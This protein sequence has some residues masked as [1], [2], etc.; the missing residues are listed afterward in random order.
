MSGLLAKFSSCSPYILA[1]ILLIVFIITFFWLYAKKRN[2]FWTIVI[3][4]VVVTLFLFAFAKVLSPKFKKIISGKK[5]QSAS[6]VYDT[7]P[8]NDQFIKGTLKREKQKKFDTLL[9]IEKKECGLRLS[10]QQVYEYTKYDN[11]II[12]TDKWNR[13]IKI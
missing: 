3:T 11:D 10:N 1:S 5:Q 2:T 12:Y 13:F 9:M 7:D 6:L 4:A 8:R